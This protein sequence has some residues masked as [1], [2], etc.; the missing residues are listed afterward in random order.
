MSAR[1]DK[2]VKT[3]QNNTKNRTDPLA[4]A[5][6]KTL[7]WQSEASAS[8]ADHGAETKFCKQNLL[9]SCNRESLQ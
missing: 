9:L 2:L 3:K 4:V 7:S 1:L 8:V 5:A 6:R